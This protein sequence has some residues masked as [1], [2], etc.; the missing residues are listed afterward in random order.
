M[1]NIKGGVFSFNNKKEI[2]K[3]INLEIKD[4]E[5]VAFIGA[6]GAGKSTLVDVI[7]GNKKLTKG[8]IKYNLK[9]NIN[10][11]IGVQFQAKE[12]PVGLK[13]KH[14]LSF[15]LKLNNLK[16]DSEK[17]KKMLKK[18]DLSE[19]LNVELKKLSG[20]QQQ[21]FNIMV[22]LIND[23]KILILDELITGLDITSQN[24]MIELISQTL[25]ENI[26][27]SLIIVSHNPVEIQK[28]VDRVI[29]LSHGEIVED[30]KKEEINK[31]YKSIDNFI[32][33]L[34]D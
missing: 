11:S 2:L 4:K 12:F 1:I 19:K 10:E 32:G 24:S 3:K 20:G 15:Y 31:K 14:L 34:H 26:N 22:A 8:E 17:V 9:K 30:I 18:F 21:K 16:L 7:I 6:N 13:V 29:V 28:L 27:M 23:P 33:A 5:R 25:K